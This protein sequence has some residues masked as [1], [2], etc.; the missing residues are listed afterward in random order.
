MDSKYLVQF[1]IITFRLPLKCLFS[2]SP[3]A[4]APVEVVS[5]QLIVATGATILHN[6]LKLAIMFFKECVESYGKTLN[7]KFMSRRS[8]TAVFVSFYNTKTRLGVKK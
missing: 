1:Q 8:E 7:S 2:N 3:T 6:R 4:N 5:M